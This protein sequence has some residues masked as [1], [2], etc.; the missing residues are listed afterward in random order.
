MNAP[1]IR[2]FSIP[3]ALGVA[4]GVALSVGFVAGWISR[5][6]NDTLAGSIPAD[7]LQQVNLRADSAATGKTMAMCTGRIDGDVESCAFVNVA[8]DEIGPVV[9]VVLGAI[10]AVVV[11]SECDSGVGHGG[12]FRGR[13]LLPTQYVLQL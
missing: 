13:S 12:S 1:R 2:W 5:P 6:A 8:I 4:L 11:A 7:V 9:E 10:V 3:L